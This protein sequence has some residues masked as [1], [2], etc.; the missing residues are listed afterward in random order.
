MDRGF[1][2]LCHA[3]E[4]C[5]LAL[6]WIH[7]VIFNAIVWVIPLLGYPPPLGYSP[8]DSANIQPFF[9][10]PKLFQKK[11]CKKHH[12]F[13]KTINFTT[14]YYIIYCKIV[15]I[16][17]MRLDKKMLLWTDE[18]NHTLH[19]LEAVW[20]IFREYLRAIIELILYCKMQVIAGYFQIL[21][22]ERSL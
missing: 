6:R 15:Y 22:L 11:R 3:W 19:F 14:V 9:Y 7:Q 4:A 17:R 18:R 12:F 1:E 21:Q 16:F 13:L 5:I 2:P 10:P 20:I 8:F